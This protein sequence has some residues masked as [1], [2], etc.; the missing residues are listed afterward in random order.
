[1]AAFLWST[2]LGLTFVGGHQ[3]FL[4]RLGMD[5]FVKQMPSPPPPVAIAPPLCPLELVRVSDNTS[6]TC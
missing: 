2:A 6:V 5:D 3:L 4:F 1:M